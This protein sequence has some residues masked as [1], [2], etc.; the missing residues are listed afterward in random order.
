MSKRKKKNIIHF[1][2]KKKEN[3]NSVTI[4]KYVDGKGKVF[5]V[6]CYNKDIKKKISK[7][8]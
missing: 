6:N 1:V 8:I 4:T 2:G 3:Q 7:I 5:Q